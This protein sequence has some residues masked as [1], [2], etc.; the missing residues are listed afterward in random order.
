MNWIRLTD[1]E[2]TKYEYSNSLAPNPRRCMYFVYK[3]IEVCNLLGF[4]VY[5]CTHY[6]IM[7]ILA[8][9]NKHDVEIGRSSFSRQII[10]RSRRVKG[11]INH[12][13]ATYYCRFVAVVIYTYNIHAR[14]T[15]IQACTT[16]DTWCTVPYIS[17]H[18]VKMQYNLGPPRNPF[19]PDNNGRRTSGWWIYWFMS[20]EI[21]G[22][23]ECGGKNKRKKDRHWPPR[24]VGNRFYLC[25]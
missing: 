6:I 8:L 11:P 9:Y 19:W 10:I 18:F 21:V 23:T 7:H 14:S 5:I 16:A 13:W 1:F 15:Y 12:V 25:L 22:H 2:Y 17:W 3:Y 24:I 20:S 4:I